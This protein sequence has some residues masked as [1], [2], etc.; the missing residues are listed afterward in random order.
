MLFNP[1][2]ATMT[3]G[4][5]NANNYV[6]GEPTINIRIDH[7]YATLPCEP[8]DTSQLSVVH[9]VPMGK[10]IDAEGTTISLNNTTATK[11]ISRRHQLDLESYLQEPQEGL[12]AA[13]ANRE[14]ARMD[15]DNDGKQTATVWFAPT[16]K[17][18]ADTSVA[19]G[20]ENQN[21]VANIYGRAA[22]RTPTTIDFDEILEDHGTLT[23]NDM[24]EDY[25]Q[26]YGGHTT[27]V[28]TRI[29]TPMRLQETDSCQFCWSVYLSQQDRMVID[30]TDGEK[31]VMEGKW[32]THRH[33]SCKNQY[34]YEIQ[35]SQYK[36]WNT[37]RSDNDNL[38]V[39]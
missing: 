19:Q 4:N 29:I 13:Y 18:K 12:D 2:E 14:F 25:D 38:E 6:S 1:D 23:T 3:S 26:A 33:A 16:N 32:T 11:N 10:V 5:D 20:E 36:E 24:G 39:E 8:D 37:P 31:L 28:L 7:E 17:D 30:E 35:C 34:A 22:S 9:V 15:T 21:K 27:I